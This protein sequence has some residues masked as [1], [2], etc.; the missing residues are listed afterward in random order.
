MKET[1]MGYKGSSYMDVGFVNPAWGVN[2]PEQQYV[3]V[4]FPYPSGAGL[5]LGHYYDY[6]IMD[7]YCRWQFFRGVCVFLPF[8][9]DA[10]GLPAEN[11]AREIGGD[12]KEVTMANI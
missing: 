12:P 1:V 3:C 11:Y 5:H 2:R 4:M 10:F 9:Y 7:S 8:G 6:A